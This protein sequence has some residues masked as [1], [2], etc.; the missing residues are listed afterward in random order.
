MHYSL[1]GFGD[2]L[3]AVFALAGIHPVGNCGCDARRKFFN[4]F[5]VAILS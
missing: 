4:R 1:I 3:A 2:V 5:Q